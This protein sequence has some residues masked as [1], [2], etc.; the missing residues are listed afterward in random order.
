MEFDTVPTL[1][2][3]QAMKYGNRVALR[4]KEFGIWRDISWN[5]YLQNVK[6]IALGLIALGLKRGECVAVIGENRQE[7][8]YADL[9]IQS[10]GGVTTGIYTTNSPDQCQYIVGHSESRFYFVEDEEQLDKALIFRKNTPKLEKIIVMDM[11]GLKHFQDPMVMSLEGLQNLGR[12]VEKTDP[13]RFERRIQ[14]RQPEDLSVLIYTS[15]TTGPP[16]GAM[17]THR[18]VLWTAETCAQAF[19]VEDTDEVLS[20][21]PLCHIAE[22]MFSLFIAIAHGYTVNFV[23]HPDTIPQNMREVSPTVLFG[24]PR[25]FEKFYSTILIT[26]SE[27]TPFKKV[28]YYLATKIGTRVSQMTLDHRSLPPWWRLLSGLAHVCV[29]GKLRERLGLEKTRVAISAAAPISPDVI[30]YFRSTG[31]DMREL[32]GQTE[33]SGPTTMHQGDDITL[34]T[35]GKPFPGMEVKIADDGEIMVKGPNV[36]KGYFKDPK[37][38]AETLKDGWLHSGDVGVIDE[39]GNLKI[40]DRKKDL[41]ITAAGKNIAPQ[42][43]ENQLKFSP[44]INDAV[45]IGD[46]RKY[47]TALIMI[48]EEN[49]IKYA[50]DHRI[51]FTTFA[52]L[53]RNAEV[54][55]L[56]QAEVNAVNN[57]LARVE[58]IKKFTIFDK[59]LDPEDGEVTPTMKVKRTFINETYEHVIEAMYRSG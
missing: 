44:Y 54:K 59:R 6:Q 4:R 33:G 24:V 40:T 27:A 8:L 56:I 12:E 42:N 21:L 35:V 9:G 43:I 10:A 57:T 48:D 15:G 58:T 31:M 39:D 2:Y 23:E 55:K 51:P 13:G 7:W 30:R 28:C 41:I 5:E 34:G 3:S 16:K 14:E 52:N 37:A 17:L 36:F 1:F 26:M 22:R 45:V 49:V 25:I 47:L 50:Q 11:K 29:L 32:Y 19:G 38:T 20:Y 18:N 53:S 46:G